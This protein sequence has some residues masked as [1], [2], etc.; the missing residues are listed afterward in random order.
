MTSGCSGVP[1]HAAA[2]GWPMTSDLRG[3]V[4]LV[5]GASQGIG[6][7]I[8]LALADAGMTVWMVARTADVLERAAADVGPSARPFAADLTDPVAR[9]ALVDAVAAEGR[10][11]DVLVHNA[12]TI[13]LG[14]TDEAS[15]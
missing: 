2:P 1:A 12:G 15:E 9:A 8:A 13:H 11:L 4:A 14:R 3:G 5:T 6:A 10:A 7:A